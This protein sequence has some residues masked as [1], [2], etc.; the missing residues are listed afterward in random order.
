MEILD[1]LKK[2]PLFENMSDSE[3][4]KIRGMLREK[5]F[6]K[7]ESIFF[8]S[9]KGDAF[10]I[11]SE[12]RVKIY[13]SSSQGKIKILDFLQKGDFFGEMSLIDQMPRSA[14]ALALENSALFT[15]RR[16]K[17]REFLINHPGLLFK[18]TRTLSR[19]L[20]RVDSE[21]QLMAF[22]SVRERLLSFLVGEAGRESPCSFPSLI[23]SV[24]TH[25]ELSEVIGTSREVISRILK[26][27]REEGIIE[28]NSKKQIRLNWSP[29]LKKFI[30]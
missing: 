26:E 1:I 10:Y 6:K 4:I 15:V 28:V 30:K 23:Q 27:L 13:K 12:G 24:F 11:V 20:R 14:N 19:R 25:Q 16:E 29:A 22:G 8:E 5:K 9:E 21:L 17:F 3:L 7:G 18:V 2:I